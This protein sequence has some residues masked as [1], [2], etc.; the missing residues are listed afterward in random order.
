MLHLPKPLHVSFVSSVLADFEATIRFQQ[1]FRQLG[2][3]VQKETVR[4]QH[5]MAIRPVLSGELNVPNN[6]WVQ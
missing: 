5:Q 3:T 6:L 1:D 4:D 2:K